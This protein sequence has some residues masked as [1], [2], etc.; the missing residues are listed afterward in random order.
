MKTDKHSALQSTLSN[1]SNDRVGETIEIQN[2]NGLDDAILRAQ[3]HEAVLP[4]SFSWWGAIGLGYSITNSWMSY[5]SCFGTT[6][7]NGGPQAVVIAVVVAGVIQWIITLG[8]SEL[9]S[10]FP[11]SG[12]QYHFTYI[13]APE[14]H[15]NFAAFAVG[16]LNVI[17]W[18]IVTCSGISLGTI[19]TLGMIS[20]WNPSFQ[21]TQWQTYLIFDLGIILTLIPIFLIPNRHMGRMT[22]FCLHLSLVGFL[23]VFITILAMCD[24]F[25]SGSTIAKQGSNSSGWPDGIAWILGIGNALY[26]YGGTDAVIHISEEITHP[27]KRLPQVMNTT[28]L[29]GVVT[30]VPL[31]VA[32]M[33]CI[34]DIDAVIASPLPSMELFYQATGSKVMATFLQAWTTAVYYLLTAFVAA[35]PSQWITCGRMTWA[36]ARDKGLPLSAYWVEINERFQLPLRTTILSACFCAIYGLLYIASTAAFNSIITTAVLALNITYCVPQGICAMYGRS[37]LPRRHLDLGKWGYIPNF[38]APLW[39]VIIGTFFCLPGSLPVSADSMNYTSVVLVALLLLIL[40]LWT[41][42]RR[43]FDG[44]TIDWSLLNELNAVDDEPSTSVVN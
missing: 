27:G 40:G 25:Q 3:G 30:T 38:F 33:F 23:L 21:A 4:R 34:Q 11:S 16:T 42:Q 24:S 1:R 41:F 43:H 12:G 39:V 7:A 26:A 44:P 35:L 29:I 6:L 17:A 31:A 22:Q 36:F 8:L 20:F 28:M 13:L 19:S 18:W 5:T 2:L 32:Y 9:A 14:K 10:A 15:R 37:K